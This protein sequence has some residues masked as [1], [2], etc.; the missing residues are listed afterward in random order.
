MI[1]PLAVDFLLRHG[2]DFNAQYRYG[3]PYRPAFTEEQLRLEEP[4]VNSIQEL[5]LDILDAEKPVILHNGMIDLVFLYHHFYA[6][7]PAKLSV[8]TADLTEMFRGGIYDTKRIPLSDVQL[9]PS[10]LEYLLHRRYCYC[11]C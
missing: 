1:D 4:A 8:F 11:G 10:Y 5:F 3:I 9:D 7:L 2:F 6:P